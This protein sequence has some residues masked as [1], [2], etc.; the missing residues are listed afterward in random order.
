MGWDLLSLLIS[1]ASWVYV[2]TPI[3]ILFSLYFTIKM[4]FI[5]GRFIKDLWSL[6]RE[7][8]PNS[9]GI[10]PFQSLVLSTASRVGSGNVLGVAFAIS[11]GG[12][13]AIF[14]MWVIAILGMALAVVESTLAQVYKVKV[15]DLYQG[16]PAYYIRRGL[17]NQK[18]SVVYSLLLILTFGFL[19]NVV[20]SSTITETLTVTTEMGNEMAMLMI[21]IVSGIVIFGG[22]RRIVHVTEILV[23]LMLFLYLAIVLYVFIRN[24][25]QVPAVFSLIMTNAFGMGE[26]VGGGI[27]MA[28]VQG[29]R[30][31][32]PSN[33]AGIGSASIA[34]A[35][36]NTSH[37]TQ[38]GIIQSFGVF[39][40]TV[41]MSSATAFI[42]LISGI[43]GHGIPNGIL[44]TQASMALYIGDIAPYFVS[45]ILLLFSFTSIISNYYYGESNVRYLSAHRGLLFGYRGLFLGMLAIGALMNA[46]GLIGI[47]A[48][49]IALM[50]VTNLYVLYK[51]QAVAKA[52]C[53]HY[54][55]Q[56]GTGKT[57]QFYAEDIPGLTNAQCWEMP[58]SVKRS[59]SKVRE[60]AYFNAMPSDPQD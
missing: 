54:A 26:F 40:D 8:V 21:L 51:L 11:I 34:G 23:P 2:M 32:L 42:I 13:G 20:Q 43:Y 12:P 55:A 4:G 60:D 3:L 58:E 49:L 17:G 47:L 6:L 18:L 30:R 19:F 31:G 22:L 57:P 15:D 46:T 24:I 52:V 50:T 1:E 7:R 33:E 35:L 10:S 5:Q 38:Q 45:V 48:F 29:A 41:I 27:G 56:R 25:E 37:P 36:A 44:L 16:G 28:L 53:Q 14:W 39:L 9:I 59:R